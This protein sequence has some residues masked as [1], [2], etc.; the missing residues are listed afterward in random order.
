MHGWRAM[1]V[2]VH[3]APIYQGH[4]V[5]VQC[6]EFWSSRN[7]PNVTHSDTDSYSDL[8]EGA[9]QLGSEIQGTQGIAADEA[10]KIEH[11][12]NH[13]GRNRN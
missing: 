9:T 8:P 1:D 12:I 2:T 10:G 11:L 13:Q 4:S 5:S 7:T 6:Y 3:L